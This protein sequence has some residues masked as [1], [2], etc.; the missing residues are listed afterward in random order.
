MIGLD[1]YSRQVFTYLY[2]S[3]NR[4]PIWSSQNCSMFPLA[5]VA[6]WLQGHWWGFISR[7]YVVWP[8]FFL[9]NVFIAL[10]GSH[11]WFYIF[12]PNVSYNLY[13]CY[14]LSRLLFGLQTMFLLKK[15]INV[16]TDFH[17]DTLR[18]LQALPEGTSSAAVLLLLGALLLEAELNKRHLSLLYSCFKFGNS[19]L[20]LLA[21]RQFQ[22]Y[23]SEGWSFFTRVK[24]ILA[25][26]ELPD[27]DY[28]WYEHFKRSV[29]NQN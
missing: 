22:F 9:M 20:V 6:G 28:M 5:F 23:D 1:S 21:K 16:L 24:H 14:V 26:Y 2:Q 7:N 25:K 11:F 10:K 29:E 13:Q 18:K 3:L 27:I 17:L 4:L 19:K 8:T 12:S 15:H